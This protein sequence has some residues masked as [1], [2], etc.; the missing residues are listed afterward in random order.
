MSV[1]LKPG[2]FSWFELTTTDQEGAKKFYSNLFG[3]T[4]TDNPMGPGASYTIFR[5]GDRDTAGAYTQQAEQRDQGVPPNWQVYVLVESADATA[6]RVAQLGGKVIV[7][8]FDVMDLGRM[9]VF[10]DP[11]GAMIAVWQAGK[12]VGVRAWGEVG[13]VGWADLQVRD[14]E[15]AAAFYSALFGWKMVAGASAHPAK[16]GEYFHIMNGDSMIGGIPPANQVDPHAHPAW[17]MY[18]ETADCA[19]S[20]RK[21]ASLGGRAYVD[22]MAIG[23]NG[24]I[25]VLADP[26]GAVFAIHQSAKR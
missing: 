3:W 26:Q 15:K 10:E 5:L 24:L 9:G 16:P 6:A 20:T 25:S 7:P 2:S 12:H 19:A 11:A 4:A 13:A 8:P 18:V 23:E 17:V 22:T 14:Q 1:A 21:A